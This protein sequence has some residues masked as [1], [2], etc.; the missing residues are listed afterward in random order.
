MESREVV[1]DSSSDSPLLRSSGSGTQSGTRSGRP[2]TIYLDKERSLDREG[3]LSRAISLGEGLHRLAGREDGPD[4]EIPIEQQSFLHSKYAS[5]M[6]TFNLATPDP[7]PSSS[8]ESVRKRRG[9]ERRKKGDKISKGLMEFIQLGE[10]LVETNKKFFRSLADIAAGSQSSKEEEESRKTHKEPR[11]VFL[12]QNNFIQHDASDLRLGKK[13][14]IEVKEGFEDG[15]SGKPVGRVTMFQGGK[16]S[17]ESSLT[18][19]DTSDTPQVSSSYIEAVRLRKKTASPDRLAPPRSPNEGKGSRSE[20]ED[21]GGKSR[22]DR[23]RRKTVGPLLKPAAT[24]QQ[25]KNPSSHSSKPSLTPVAEPI[26]ETAQA[27]LVPEMPEG[28]TLLEMTVQLPVDEVFGMIFTESQFYRDWLFDPKS[29]AKIQNLSCS[30]FELGG[31]AGEETR[32]LTYERLQSFGFTSATIKVSQQMIRRSWSVA[33]QVYGVDI[34][35]GNS[36]ALYADSF[37]LH[38][39]YRLES[40][41]ATSCK[42]RIIA[43]V[44]FVTRTMLRGKIETELWSG[45]QKSVGLL[46]EHLLAAATPTSS[47]S[48]S[49]P[50]PT[51]PGA[52]VEK[53]P[54]LGKVE[55]LG[56]AARPARVKLYPDN[57]QY[58]GQLILLVILL[59]LTMLVVALFKLSAT[60]DRMDERLSNIEIAFNALNMV[61]GSSDQT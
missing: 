42:L 36:G 45:Q 26:V 27:A 44:D 23:A 12:P 28:R 25:T 29:G 33:G 11:Q 41:G 48:T 50:S 53:A 22:V 14:E 34:D 19:G 35:T 31:E 49:T 5:S 21:S 4:G 10:P 8:E 55:K 15:E 37:I 51:N 39:H 2:R 46:K 40:K 3:G 43:S 54:G 58:T 47:A 16:L 6:S 60:L 18:P 17:R 7:P 1:T 57:Y 20:A 59:I 13:E 52:E 9:K 30:D 24:G 56:R 38:E 32:S 61:G